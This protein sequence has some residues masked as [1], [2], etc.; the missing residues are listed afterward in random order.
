LER[1]GD[2]VVTLTDET[3]RP[4]KV[5]LVEDN[6]ADVFLIERAFKAHP[7]LMWLTLARDGEEA[8]DCL[9]GQG[10]FEEPFHPDIIL[11][12][13]GIPKKSGLEVLREIRADSAMDDIPVIIFTNSNLD[14]D[15]RKAYDFRANFFVTK[16]QDLTLLFAAIHHIEEVFLKD[17]H[18]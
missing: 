13:L 11:L 9:K 17:L 16:P 1:Q 2:D 3:I 8:V 14:S 10:N 12:D 18:D 15:I 4:I 7:R 5:F 6:M